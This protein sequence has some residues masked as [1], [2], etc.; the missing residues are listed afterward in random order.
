MRRI[1]EKYLIAGCLLAVAFQYAG[2]PVRA[3]GNGALDRVTSIE[4]CMYGSDRHA[5]T[6]ENRL[7][8]LEKDALGHP[9]A[10]N[11]S[12][13]LDHL[14]H[15]IGKTHSVMLPPVAPQLDTGAQVP[16]EAPTI[17]QGQTNRSL[18]N[19]EDGSPNQAAFLS[20]NGD[21]NVLHGNATEF[22]ARQNQP[23]KNPFYPGQVYQGNAQQ[24]PPLRGQTAQS[25]PVVPIQQNRALG[26]GASQ[27]DTSVPHTSAWK[28]ASR[29][30]VNAAYYGGANRVPGLSA[31]HCP[32]CRLLSF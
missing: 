9:Q 12:Q 1:P 16:M 15:V 23:F 31:L 25:F 7:Q 8:A 5:M 6:L 26:T 32:I 11:V 30:A 3:S 21:Q 28:S 4:Q 17:V 19:A 14:E 18:W 22:G 29:F 13:R 24:F 10:G 27:S 20:R 2:Q